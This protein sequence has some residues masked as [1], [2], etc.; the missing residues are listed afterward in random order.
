MLA[1]LR[2]KVEM[3]KEKRRKKKIICKIALKYL[4]TKYE[5]RTFANERN[6]FRVRAP[7]AL[8]SDLLK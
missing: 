6:L 3:G 7:V 8:A 1:K 4:V 2:R 5:M